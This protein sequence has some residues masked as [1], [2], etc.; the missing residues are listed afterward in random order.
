[1]LPDVAG[2]HFHRMFVLHRACT[3]RGW[4]QASE[5][6]N[7]GTDYSDNGTCLPI[8]TLDCPTCLYNTIQALNHLAACGPKEQQKGAQVCKP[9]LSYL[10]FQEEKDKKC[11]AGSDAGYS[12]KLYSPPRGENY[13]GFQ[14]WQPLLCLETK[15]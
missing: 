14:E 6:G 3:A 8:V 7:S 5:T 11:D 10:G 2:P 15:L 9:I 13:E 12:C 1:M 4:C